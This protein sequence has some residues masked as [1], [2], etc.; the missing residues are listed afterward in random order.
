MGTETRSTQRLGAV[1]SSGETSQRWLRLAEA[2]NGW[3]FA[4]ARDTTSGSR[5]GAGLERAG[6][7]LVGCATQLSARTGCAGLERGRAPFPVATNML[8]GR[9]WQATR[10]F[11]RGCQGQWGCGGSQGYPRG[12]LGPRGLASCQ[13]WSSA[14]LSEIEAEG[15]T[16]RA[17]PRSHPERILQSGGPHASLGIQREACVHR[18]RAF[19]VS[20]LRAQKIT[21]G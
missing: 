7:A 6:L 12:H 9:S 4:I 11:W 17:S 5:V 10:Q 20:F 18:L 21:K 16:R 3:A 1:G 14:R 19:S 2:S 15:L 8:A 13:E